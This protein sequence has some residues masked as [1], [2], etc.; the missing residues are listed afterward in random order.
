[1]LKGKKILIGISGSIA[2]YKSLILI[3]LLVKSGAEVK[4]VMT[5]AATD[6]ITALSAATLSKHPVLNDIS[7]EAQ[8]NNHVELGRWADLMVIAPLSCN[9]LAKMANGICD[10][11]LMAVYLSATCNVVVAPAMDDDMWKH[12]ATKQN[13]E[14]IKLFGN[15]ILPVQ[16]GE[17]ASGLT[18]EGRMA[19][20]ET[21]IQTIEQH[22]ETAADL[23]NKKVIIT[24]GPTFEAID[25][26]RFIGN[27]SSGK[28][29]IALAQEA[30]KRGA[31]VTVV[32]GPTSFPLNL[33]GLKIIRVQSAAQMYQ[34]ATKGFKTSDIAV[35]CAAVAD[36]SPVKAEKEKIK[37]T[38]EQLELKLTRTKDILKQIGHTK[39]KKQVVVGFALET[40]NEKEYAIKKLKEK[41]A[42][43]IVLNSHNEKNKAFGGDQNQVTVYDRQEKEYIIPLQSKEGV[44]KEIIDLIVKKIN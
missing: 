1:M 39:T 19:E 40:Q 5:K 14:K 3:R 43:L 22:F 15:L 37:K 9:S 24:A 25:P 13:L 6:F 16:F 21:I 18:G 31:Q 2:A 29:G 36:Y 41:N 28:M 42:D 32:L 17:L 34:A 33:G 7:E 26:V 27:H 4:V 8:W 12:P 35:L 20:P 38:G 23:K 44:A 11:L 10:N 30:K